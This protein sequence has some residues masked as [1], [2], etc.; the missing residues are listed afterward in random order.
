MHKKT[1]FTILSNLAFTLK[2]KLRTHVVLK[3]HFET[4]YM[5]LSLALEVHYYSERHLQ[6]CLEYKEIYSDIFTIQEYIKKEG[7]IG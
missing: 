5:L 6:N 1:H 2:G 3:N 7:R 4:A